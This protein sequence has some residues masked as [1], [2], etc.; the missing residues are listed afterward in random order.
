MSFRALPIRFDPLNLSSLTQTL[1]QRRHR[2]LVWLAGDPQWCRQQLPE[3][4]TQ[5]DLLVDAEVADDN[6]VLVTDDPLPPL[7][8][9]S[10]RQTHQLLGQTLPWVAFDA[11]SGFNPNCFGQ[12]AGCVAAGGW[13]ILISP[14]P[15]EW[16]NYPDPEY[17]RLCAEP[18]TPD[19]LT[20]H[21]LSRLIRELC[22]DNGVVRVWQRQARQLPAWHKETPKAWEAPSG[23]APYWSA[24]QQRTVTTL[25]ERLQ[26]R[27]ETLVLTADRGRGKT[28]AIGLALVECAA[29]RSMKVVVTAPSRG[30]LDALYE[31]VVALLPELPQQERWQRFGAL[32]L[33]FVPPGELASSPVA[34]DLLVVDEAAAIATPVLA[35]LATEY[36]R[37]VFATTQHGYEGNGRGF[38]LR[39]LSELRQR[40]PHCLE[41]HLDTPVR[42][43]PGDPLEDLV[44]RLLLLDAEPESPPTEVSAWRI[45]ALSQQQ[46]VA[47]EV[48]LRGLFGLL[49][50]AHYRT[51]P[52]DLRVLLDTPNLRIWTMEQDG[53]LLACA[54]VAEEGRLSPTLAEGV[55]RGVRRPTGHLLPQALIA[56]EG[57]TE[58]APWQAWRV[59]RIAVHPQVQHLGLGSELLA[60]ISRAAEAAG[61][62]YLGA[63]FAA[64]A[65]LLRYWQRNRYL[66]VRVGDHCDPVSASHAVIVLKPLSERVVTWFRQARSAYAQRVRYRLSGALETLDTALLPALFDELEAPRLSEYQ[67]Q[68][69]Q[70]FAYYRRSLESAL[71]EIDRLIGLTLPQWDALG[72][73]DAEQRLLIARVWRQRPPSEVDS[74]AGARA[75]LKVL[76][77]LVARLLQHLDAVAHL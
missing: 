51:T 5:L 69:L 13:L 26:Q 49:I 35:R 2:A 8:S 50:L 27:R 44:N 10:L 72:L 65:G 33:C 23:V 42:W 62:D 73:T 6:G 16:R 48:G 24:D 25:V 1:Q 18:W 34:A 30:A 14:L 54:L 4:L 46:L 68:Q 28:A 3:L 59:V 57:W 40:V 53:R 47:N 66:P 52:G 29:R 19:Q 61:V 74:P 58:V 71:L 17:A 21:F 9:I 55:W 63:S 76:R 20:P 38:T 75:Q 11:Y 32:E 70:G 43:A 37:I 36:R 67:C 7:A 45:H 31:R 64:T 60:Q 15:P 39:F 41:L 56:H 12:V 22:Q 77:E